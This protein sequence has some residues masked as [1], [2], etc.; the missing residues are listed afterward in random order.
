MVKSSLQELVADRATL[1][2]LTVEQ[3]HRMLETGIL[4]DCDPYELLDGYLVRKDRSKTGA[5]P[6]TVG[7]DHSG[8][9]GLLGELNQGLKRHGFH[10]R[11]QQPVTM[12]PDSEPEPD[13]AVVR[14]TLRDISGRHPV[15][16]DIAC[17]F[18]VADSSL[19]RD[20]V[21]KQRIYADNGIPQYVI[22]NLLE[23][24]VEVY[25]TPLRGQGRYQ[26]VKVLRAGQTFRIALGDGAYLDVLVESLLP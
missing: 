10:M 16:A 21:T 8:G 7:P 12:L 13:G 25:S 6:M 4:Q 18:E 11:L 5:D 26:D 17:L 20:R 14:G 2:P 9:V 3:Y 19:R 15:P 22:V 23:A 1:M 24:V